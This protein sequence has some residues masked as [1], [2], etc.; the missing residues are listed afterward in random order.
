MEQHLHT[1]IHRQTNF[2]FVI[3]YCSRRHF[4]KN[5]VKKL[6]LVSLI[7]SGINLMFIAC[8][9]DDED[10]ATPTITAEIPASIGTNEFAGKTWQSSR[11]KITFSDTTS[12]TTGESSDSVKFKYSYD[13]TKKLLYLAEISE[14]LD[15][16][17]ISSVNDY[18][19]YY[20]SKNKSWTSDSE[21]Y[22]RNRGSE[23]FTIPKVFSYSIS[24]TALEL[25]EYFTGEIPS[26]A[27]F[28][29]SPLQFIKNHITFYSVYDTQ[30]S[31]ASAYLTFSGNSFSGDIYNNEGNTK[32]GT[33]AGTYTT[34]GTGTSNSSVTL[35]FTSLPS[36]LTSVKTDT[37][38][39][40]P[41]SAGTI[42]FTLVQ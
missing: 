37:E 9:S 1:N 27:D 13:S 28:Y 23:I 21:T 30:Y 6:F 38:Y 7:L 24:G 41:Q 17:T 29:K 16:V 31:N 42:K 39:T 35:K 19:N 15:G 12:D 14:V 8:N 11:E 18:V 36:D 10:D 5:T 22:Y 33:L 25:K 34:K 3:T 26:T 2:N 40:L 32:L 20:K 4:M